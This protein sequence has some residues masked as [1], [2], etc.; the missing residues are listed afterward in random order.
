[1]S[2]RVDVILDI[3]KIPKWYGK[4]MSKFEEEKLFKLIEEASCAA[5]ARLYRMLDCSAFC[6]ERRCYFC[7][8]FEKKRKL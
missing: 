1:M 2:E 8:N 5:D 3:F 6:N 7:G 4:I